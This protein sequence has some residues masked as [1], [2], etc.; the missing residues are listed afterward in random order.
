M[1]I[2]NAI[3]SIVEEKEA[4]VWEGDV[5]PT[6]DSNGRYHAPTDGYVYM[7]RVFSAGEFLPEEF[8]SRMTV[9]IKIKKDL[10]PVIQEF[11][12]GGSGKSWMERDTEVCYF[13]GDVSKSQKE[14]I[15]ALLPS[16]GRKKIVEATEATTTKTWKFSGARVGAKIKRNY[17]GLHTM[18]FG[19]LCH[20]WETLAPGTEFRIDTDGKFRSNMDGKIVCYEYQKDYIEG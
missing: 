5:E 1:S 16:G 12:T 17:G 6:M 11:L 2:L 20:L 10:V 4:K 7:G 13:Y 19:L 3:R 18:D 8:G 9:R 14:K 15:E